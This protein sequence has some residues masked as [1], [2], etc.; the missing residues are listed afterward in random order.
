VIPNGRWEEVVLLFLLRVQEMICRA[1]LSAEVAK[2]SGVV[3]AG[4]L[5]GG[6]KEKAIV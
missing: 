6:L 3:T 5:S 1:R 4:D 2:C